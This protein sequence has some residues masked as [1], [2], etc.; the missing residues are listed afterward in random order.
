MQDAVI[1][2]AL[3]LSLYYKRQDVHTLPVQWLSIN[4]LNIDIISLNYLD[5]F[6]VKVKILLS[7]CVFYSEGGLNKMKP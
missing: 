3:H 1:I 6:V 4:K 7:L 5:M 2:F